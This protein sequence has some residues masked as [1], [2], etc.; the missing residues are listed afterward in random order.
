MPNGSLHIVKPL[1]H[2]RNKQHTLI[3]IAR[4]N[5]GR[6]AAKEANATVIINVCNRN[7][8]DPEFQRPAYSFIVIADA[9]A[10]TQVGKKLKIKTLR[11]F[12]IDKT[13]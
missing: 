13:L 7:D 9:L 1:D 12:D 8:N 3:I 11:R 4:D 2:E 5:P 10:V 6:D